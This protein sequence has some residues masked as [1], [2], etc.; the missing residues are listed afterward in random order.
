MRGR[1]PDFGQGGARDVTQHQEQHQKQGVS[2]MSSP[3]NR[4]RYAAVVA[5]LLTL[6]VTGCSGDEEPAPR[7]EPSESL[8]EPSDAPTLEIEP[9]VVSGT[10]VGRLPRKDRSRVEGVVSRTAVGFL[11]A[12]YVAGDYPRSDFSGTFPGFTTGAAAVARR[13]RNLLTN[14]R[15][16]E[17]I[18]SVTPTLLRVKVDLLAVNKRAVAATAHVK[19]TF[20]TSGKATKR[21]SVQGELRLTKRDGDWKI[22]AY[23][24]TKGVR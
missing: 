24:L 1:S 7:S 18:D 20:R 4:R 2:S 3:P 17:R 12:A 15:I 5:I 9:V 14:Q 6:S 22:F 10:I 16:G 19:L 23:D 21:V 13:D 11:E 8:A